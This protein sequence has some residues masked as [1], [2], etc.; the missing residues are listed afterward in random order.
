MMFLQMSVS[1]SNCYAEQTSTS[2]VIEQKTV[3]E[4]TQ[5]ISDTIMSPFCPGRTLSACPSEDARQLR[6]QISTSLKQ[7][8]SAAAVKRQL[9]AKY[10]PELTGLPENSSFGRLANDAPFYFLIFGV[11]IV[12]L[13]IFVL[14]KRKN[15]SNLKDN[16][17]EHISEEALKNLKERLTREENKEKNKED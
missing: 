4:L 17:E 16:L 9:T 5:E 7:G 6:T 2:F 14:G 13:T 11:L 3:E 8:Y 10:G 12:F 1:I 15:S